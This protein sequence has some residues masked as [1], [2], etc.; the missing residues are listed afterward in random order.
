MQTVTVSKMEWFKTWQWKS[1]LISALVGRIIAPQ[2]SH[3]LIPGTCAY[4]TLYDKENFADVIKD[5]KMGRLSWIPD[6]PNVITRVL[7]SG[8]GMQK[9]I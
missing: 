4:V 3:T 9:E 6:G 7:K 5:L 2:R 1:V 8:R